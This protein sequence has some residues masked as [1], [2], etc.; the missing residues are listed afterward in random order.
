VVGL[1]AI[2]ALAIAR[3]HPFIDGNKRT[4]YVAMEL[5]LAKNGY[6]F[7]ASDADSVVTTLRMAAGE[8]S[9]DDFTRWVK[10]Y[11]RPRES[12]PPRE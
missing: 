5:F 12:L 9:D 6:T 11:A 1:A 2:Y 3:N 10:E 7:A 8:V 4:A